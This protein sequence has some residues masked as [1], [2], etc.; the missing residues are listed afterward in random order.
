MSLHTPRRRSYNLVL[1][2]FPL[3][4]L[5]LEE[6]AV[7]CYAVGGVVVEDEGD[8]VTAV[9]VLL[10]LNGGVYV[11]KKQRTHSVAVRVGAVLVLSRPALGRVPKQLQQAAAARQSVVR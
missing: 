3:K 1:G 5:A 11:V 2:Q 4:Y 7:G 8:C 10:M 6:S 9:T